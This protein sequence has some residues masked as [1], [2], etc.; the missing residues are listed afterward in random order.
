MAITTPAGTAK[1]YRVIRRPIITEK[2][3][4][5]KETQHTVVFEVAKD[6]TKTE[7]KEAVQRVFK[8]KVDHVRT[9]IYHGKFRRR[10]RAEGFRSD[11]KKAYVRL[12][13]GEKMIEYAENL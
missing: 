4:G 10:G 5:V 6:A 3:L 7:I 2:G 12:A 11:W 8:V 1:I 9:A 13:P